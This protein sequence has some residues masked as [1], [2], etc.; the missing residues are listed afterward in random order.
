LYICLLKS[1]ILLKKIKKSEFLSNSLILITGTF[2][3]QLIPIILQPFLRRIF[4]PSDFGYFAIFTTIVGVLI[5]L[6]NFK[7]EN[8]IVIA[9]DDETANDLLKGGIIIS[10]FFSLLVLILMILFESTWTAFFEISDFSKK[11]FWFIPISVFALSSY[12]CMNFWFIRFK[13][14]KTSSANKLIRRSSEGIGQLFFGFLKKNK[15][16]TGSY[17]GLIIGAVIG[18]ISNFIFGLWQCK[19]FGL[20]WTYFN[21]KNI[22]NALIKY[23]D[24]PVFNALPS[25]LNTFSLMFPV[26]IVS[27]L[28]GKEITGQFDLSRVVLALPLALISISVSQVYLQR[29]SEQIKNKQKIFNEY[30]KMLFLLSSLS[31]PGAIIGYLICEPIFTLFFGENWDTAIKITQI[32]IFSYAIKFIVSPLSVSIIALE[33]LK[34][35]AL[36][37]MT[38]F[39]LII[40][41]FFLKGKSIEEFFIIYAIIEVGIYL[42]Y[43]AITTKLILSHDNN[44]RK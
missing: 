14:F 32:L 36:W 40:S 16:Q 11:I 42:L 39:S 29:I 6:S 9:K 28:Y 21:L 2:I 12:Q 22:K 13:K 3:A 27:Y 1:P 38:Y 24:F 10:F 44:L 17:N 34:W 37:Q 35:R 15:V 25:F 18:A 23:K 20:R 4:S 26:I 43:F 8:A 19:K 5:S 41:L 31:I 30:K 33:K 7:Y